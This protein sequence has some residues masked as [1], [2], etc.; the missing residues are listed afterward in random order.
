EHTGGDTPIAYFTGAADSNERQLQDYLPALSTISFIQVAHEDHTVLNLLKYG[1]SGEV[2]FDTT[3][4]P[5]AAYL[6]EALGAEGIEHYVREAKK[7]CA[8]MRTAQ[9]FLD[10]LPSS[11]VAA[12]ARAASEIASGRRE[13]LLEIA[14]KY[15]TTG[16]RTKK[17]KHA[18]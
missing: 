12:L 6:Y 3:A 18:A 7:V 17:R 2:R 11:L 14:E 9:E 10:R 16:P 5:I 4:S 8:G 13:R 15:S 1:R